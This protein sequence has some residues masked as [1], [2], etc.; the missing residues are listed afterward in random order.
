M[1]L[2]ELLRDRPGESLEEIGGWYASDPRWAEKVAGCIKMI[3]E[4]GE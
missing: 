3:V 2:A 1:F 4:V